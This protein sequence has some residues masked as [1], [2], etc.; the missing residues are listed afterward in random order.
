MAGVTFAAVAECETLSTVK[1]K[2]SS[3]LITYLLA[4]GAKSTCQRLYHAIARENSAVLQTLL[5]DCIEAENDIEGATII[6]LD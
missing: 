1:T 6:E 5:A 3:V 4:Q 2:E